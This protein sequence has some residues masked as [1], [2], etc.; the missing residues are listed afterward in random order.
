M[1]WVGLTET[2]YKISEEV[3]SN[4]A[5]PGYSFV[6]QPSLSNA[7]GAGFF[8]SDKLN[9]TVRDD[10]S[11][12]TPDYECLWIEVQSD[13]KDDLI[14]EV[15]YRHL[16]SNR[17][18]FMAYLDIVMDKISREK[19]YCVMMGDF[20]LNLLNADSHSGTDEFLN[21]LGSYFF[22]P[23]ILQ[24]TRITHH[25][26]TLIDVFFNSISHHTISGN[27]LYDLTDHLP[28]FLIINKFSTI[29]KGFKIFRD[30]SHFNEQ[31]FLQEMQSVNWNLESLDDNVNEMFDT[32]NSELMKII[33]KHIPLKQLS[34]KDVKHRSKPWITSGIRTSLK[35]ITYIKNTLNLEQ[36]IITKNL[37]CIETK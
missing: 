26:A 11:E 4:H 23:H 12:S 33:D 8:V 27:I 37:N 6:S 5:I 19:K 13:S 2:K 34:R 30:F 1:G 10:L 24:P 16:H 17:E 28:N 9:F 36:Y 7:G 21:T 3:L 15:I 18:A 35:K 22:N 31:N 25:T 20:N 32:F 29:P 14:C